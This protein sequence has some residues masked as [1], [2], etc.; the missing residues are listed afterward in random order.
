MYINIEIEAGRWHWQTKIFAQAQKFFNKQKRNIHTFCCCC[1]ANFLGKK[2]HT[3]GKINIFL[4]Q[5]LFF[6]SFPVHLL[7][8]Q[9]NFKQF[10]F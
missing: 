2:K 8:M 6:I 5:D 3:K 7:A 4:L 9:F 10:S 1:F